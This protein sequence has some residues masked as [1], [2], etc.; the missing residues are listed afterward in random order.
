MA[1]EGLGLHAHS[2]SVGLDTYKQKIGLRRFLKLLQTDHVH[3]K[4]F[5]DAAEAKNYPMYLFMYHPEYQMLDFVGTKRWPLAKDHRAAKEIAFRVSLMLNREA[6]KNDNRI[7]SENV[8]YFEAM[9][10]NKA[11]P[12]P[13][14][15]I[16][17]LVIYAYG[18]NKDQIAHVK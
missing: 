8:P 3:G 1:T 6:R 5:I 11:E 4:Q 10:I 13:Y 15:M 16:G 17:D 7:K 2:Y 9:T 12:R 14:P 18:W